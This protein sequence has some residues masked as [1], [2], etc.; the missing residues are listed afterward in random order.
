[1]S[2][3]TPN[4]GLHLPENTDSMDSF[5][6]N[7]AEDMETIDNNLGGGGGGGGGNTYIYGVYI[8]TDNSNFI[9]INDGSVTHPTYSYTA[10]DDCFADIL[11]QGNSGATI[12]VKIDGKVIYQHIQT[13]VFLTNIVPL[14][15]GQVISFE[16]LTAYSY[17]TIYGVKPSP[18][19]HDVSYLTVVNGEVNIVYD[20]G[21]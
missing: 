3:L 2:T 10:T 19:A 21:T 12:F 6:D 5:F 15:K 20:D 4:Y 1:M 11:I 17:L 9:S 7:Y 14:R 18:S 8:D 16:N 13:P